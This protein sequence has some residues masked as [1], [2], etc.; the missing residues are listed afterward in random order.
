MKIKAIEGLLK[1]ECIYCSIEKKKSNIRC[2]DCNFKIGADGLEGGRKF[3]PF[4][5]YTYPKSHIFYFLYYPELNFKFPC[6]PTIDY[7]GNTKDSHMR[8]HWVIHHEDGNHNNDNIWNLILL[9]N[10]EHHY[11][12]IKQFNPMNNK[13]ILLKHSS[14]IRRKFNNRF[15]SGEYL[16]ENNIKF[17]KMRDYISNLSPGKYKINQ[18]LSK[19]LGYCETNSLRIGIQSI[20]KNNDISNIKLIHNKKCG[21]ASKWNLEIL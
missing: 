12:H 1:D 8:W 11:L 13:D 17:F 7:I 20:I 10:T 19:F 21:C 6:I 14:T 18:T 16:D 4:G 5:L 2:T 15:L 9:I 3:K